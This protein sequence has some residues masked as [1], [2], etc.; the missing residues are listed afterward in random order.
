M[1]KKTKSAPV[2]ARGIPAEDLQ[3]AV[4]E[5]IKQAKE[6]SEYSGRAGQALK[7]YIERHNLNVKAL[8]T[9]ITASKMEEAKRQDFLRSLVDYAYKLG[10]FDQIDAFSDMLADF[11]TIIEEVESRGDRPTKVDPIVAATVQ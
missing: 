1:A 9:A 4:K 7:T 6:A 3:R 5:H 8:R 10:F 2:D 11:K